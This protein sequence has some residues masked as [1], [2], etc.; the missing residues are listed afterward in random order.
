MGAFDE[1][2]TKERK[3][4]WMMRWWHRLFLWLLPTRKTYGD[5]GIL[6]TKHFGYHIFVMG[7]KRLKEK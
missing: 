6:Y 5:G 4:K 7:W 3:P 1:W 2:N